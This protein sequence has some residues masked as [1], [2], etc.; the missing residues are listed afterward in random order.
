MAYDKTK[1]NT[2]TTTETLENA[3][4]IGITIA[5]SKIS[6]AVGISL[7]GEQLLLIGGAIK[8]LISRIRN[9]IKHRR[10]ERQEKRDAS[11]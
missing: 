11:I 2:K 3:G 6:E 8:I 9:R 7:T 4:T 5:A 10:L 1:A